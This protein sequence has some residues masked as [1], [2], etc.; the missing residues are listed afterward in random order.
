MKGLKKLKNLSE[1][2][3]RIFI[4]LILFI[5]A[6]P[7]TLLVVRNLSGRM[8][9]TQETSLDFINPLPEIEEDQGLNQLIEELTNIAQTA[10]TTYGQEKTATTTN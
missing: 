6:I 7:L 2:G 8:N 10:T 5:L 3:K 9:R 1:A 4:F